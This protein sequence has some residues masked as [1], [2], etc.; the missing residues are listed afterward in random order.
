MKTLLINSKYVY[1]IG[2]FGVAVLLLFTI[3][4]ISYAQGLEL[5][6]PSTE[7]Y[8]SGDLSGNPI[9]QWIQFFMNVLTVV[10]IAGSAVMI[11]IA[12]LQ[13]M[14]ARDNAQGVQAAKQKITN[15]FIG[16]LSYF[17]L[18]GFMQ[19]LIPGGVF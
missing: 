14:S 19:W 2:A 5:P 10:I 12:G 16:L 7:V 17:F 8:Q 4:D 15:V 1:F 18:Y 11:A 3:T 13:Y 9:I 6:K